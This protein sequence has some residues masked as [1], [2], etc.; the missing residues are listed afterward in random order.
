MKYWFLNNPNTSFET[1]PQR[2]EWCEL[3][4]G[5]SLISDLPLIHKKENSKN[6]KNNS[7]LRHSKIAFYWCLDEALIPKIDLNRTKT[8]R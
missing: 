1:G 8:V 2:G 6:F 7:N 5:V 3:E 4:I